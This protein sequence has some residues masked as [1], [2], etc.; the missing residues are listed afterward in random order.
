MEDIITVLV[1]VLLPPLAASGGGAS[2]RQTMDVAMLKLAVLTAIVMLAGAR[3][4]P[5]LLLRVARLRSRELFTHRRTGDGHVHRD[6][7]VCDLRCVT[8]RVRDDSHVHLCYTNDLFGH[9]FE[10]RAATQADAF[11]DR[12]RRERR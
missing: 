12:L 11:F 6:G 10:Q 9:P 2:L 5:W 4:V 8:E 1:L 7:F 3:F